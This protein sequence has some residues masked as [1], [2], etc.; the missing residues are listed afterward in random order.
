[1][2]DL[3]R[4]SDLDSLK[5]AESRILRGPITP[6]ESQN[7]RR[8]QEEGYNALLEIQGRCVEWRIKS[9][10]PN[11]E[12]HYCEIDDRGGWMTGLGLA[13]E[14]VK[15]SAISYLSCYVGREST[16]LVDL[17]RE[18]YAEID[19]IKNI[20]TPDHI[21]FRFIGGSVSHDFYSKAITIRMVCRF[22]LGYNKEVDSDELH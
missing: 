8:L 1:M 3:E 9:I 4:M 21:F 15:E 18:V 11:A 6:T 17:M 7:V 14:P 22:S 2:M 19:E 12:L 5:D 20:K 13:K 10:F 16:S